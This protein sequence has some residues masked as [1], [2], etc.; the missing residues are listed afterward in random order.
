VPAHGH[1]VRLRK[2]DDLVGDLELELI[3]RR[4]QRRPDQIALRRDLLAMLT[5][6]SAIGDLVR[7]RSRAH[8]GAERHPPRSAGAHRRA[9]RCDGAQKCADAGRDRSSA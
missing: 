8:A 5:Q 1:A 4:T 3:A 2:R 6:R 7:Q 9:S